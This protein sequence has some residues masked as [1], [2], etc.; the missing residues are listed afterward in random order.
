MGT[1]CA[2]LK[3]FSFVYQPYQAFFKMTDSSCKL[4][5]RN[6]SYRTSDSDLK[7]YYEKW[8]TVSTA[9]IM[10]DKAT[11]KSK[12]FGFVNYLKPAMVDEAMSNRPH[13]L[14]EKKLEP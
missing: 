13:E 8:G 11:G 9:Q 6:I 14:D 12:G 1:H 4:F 3:K 7:E 10:K 2:I 5:I